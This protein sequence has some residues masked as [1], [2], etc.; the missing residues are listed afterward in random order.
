[1]HLYTT[2]T[3]P[4]GRRVAVVMKEKGIEIPITE[5]DLRGAENLSDE[6]KAKNVIG[7][8]PV[9]WEIH[10]ITLA[11]GTSHF[12]GMLSFG[13]GTSASSPIILI[14]L[15]SFLFRASHWTEM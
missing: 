15:P 3:S 8:V 5:I 12:S 9:R 6:F 10:D 14:I 13:I 2:S 7:R 1:M 11:A 4:N